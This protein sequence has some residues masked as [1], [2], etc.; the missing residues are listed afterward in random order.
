[1]LPVRCADGKAVAPTEE[2]IAA[3]EY[4]L[5]RALGLGC[6]WPFFSVEPEPSSK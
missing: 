4:P 1:M 6:E 3:S 2:A 5:A